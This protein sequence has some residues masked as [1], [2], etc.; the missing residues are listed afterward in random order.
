VAGPLLL[1]IVL[2]GT[3][4]RVEDE[5]DY[6]HGEFADDCT[7]CHGDDGWVPVR[8]SPEFDH[9]ARGFPRR[10]SHERAAC[11]HCHTTLDFTQADPSC[12]ACHLDVHRGELGIDCERCHTARNFIDRSR[13]VRRHTETR[14][15]LNG[16][17]LAIDCEDCHRLDSPGILQWVNTPW[18]CQDCHLDAYQATVDPDHQAE[19]FPL[20][21]RSCHN[22]RAFEPAS[23]NHALVPPGS[24]CVDCHLDDYLATTEP[25][26]ETA[27]FPQDCEA[28]HSTRSWSPASFRDHDTQYFPI[29]SGRHRP[30][31]DRCTDCHTNPGDF[32][33]FSCLGCH[34]NEQ[35]LT[36]EHDGVPGFVYASPA[37]YACHPDGRADD[38]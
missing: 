3:V 20:D 36:R 28:C 8:I 10:N 38:D 32:G 23:F 37:C 35:E 26:H 5:P 1:L 18:D 15:P 33:S 34:D 29:Y 9:A 6:P 27:M 17:H 14:F 11:R 30:V 22:T 7:L 13:M 25:D 21:C 24:A 31:W 19:G 4:A 2:A 12:V 16:A